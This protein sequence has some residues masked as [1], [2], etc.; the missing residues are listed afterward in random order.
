[1]NIKKNPFA[2]IPLKQM[3]LWIILGSILLPLL[4]AC[5]YFY[6]SI[7][8]LLE[9]NL[10]KNLEQNITQTTKMLESAFQMVN[11]TT[12]QI[13]ASASVRSWFMEEE[14]GRPDSY[15]LSKHR[16][17]MEEEL[18]HYMMF[19]NAWDARLI[20]T[21]YLFL[22]PDVY[23]SVSR[24]SR[25]AEE[26]K[27]NNLLAYEKFS[28]DR[29]E[30][31][32]FYPPSVEDPTIYSVRS[33]TYSNHP[34]KK[35]FLSIGTWEEEL[36]QISSSIANSPD[37]LLYLV[38]DGGVIFSSHDKS[39]LGQTLKPELLVFAHSS[40]DG[41][42]REMV[43]QGMPYFFAAS[44]VGDFGLTYI[45]GIPK[46]EVLAGLSASITQFAG[47]MAVLMVG[48]LLV[49]LFFSLTLSGFLDR[50]LAS[51]R[52]VGEGDYG[53][54]MPS[55]EN[56]DL[57]SI[58]TTFNQMT[59]RINYLIHE[60]YEEQLMRKDAEIKLLH[61]Q[62]NPHFLF[63]TLTAIGYRARLGGDQVLYEMVAALSELMQANIYRGREEKVRISEELEY[64]RL[65]LYLQKMRFGEKL[66]YDISV[67]EPELLDAF[68]PK[69]SIEPAVENA[70]VHGF[71]MQ[72]APAPIALKI[73]QEE[74]DVIF[75]VTDGGPGFPEE[76]LNLFKEGNIPETSR[77]GI[78]NT[79]RRIRLIY[80][81]GYG[82]RLY[83]LPE[84]GAC[85]EGHFPVDFRGD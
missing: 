77:V 3:I 37:A 63:N 71:E 65:Y 25:S 85:M 26:I 41:V 60:V 81:S 48:C 35:L 75:E 6:K 12:L 39:L 24:S 5:L 44:P 67:K 61:S 2:R 16:N 59:A 45:V 29:M 40:A 27:R 7:S 50:L 66:Q 4:F 69:L 9:T 82:L 1:M 57:N 64:I 42:P 70:V 18:V 14:P 78:Y 23:C 22:Y 47:M 83:N 31:I 72:I 58:S 20:N 13:S 28:Q 68:I 54:R 8:A 33:F 79:H 55:Y 51:I 56:P 43:L 32:S 11:T 34:D 62:M 46:K 52:I 30:G 76:I 84:G 53:N 38:D 10:K 15:E 80:G 49:G 73:W 19:N 74:G 36:H 21:A 17:A